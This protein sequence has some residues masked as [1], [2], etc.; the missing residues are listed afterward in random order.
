MNWS[1]HDYNVWLDNHQ[2]E[3]ARLNILRG[4]IENHVNFVRSTNKDSFV[5]SYPILVKL[6]KTAFE[7]F[8]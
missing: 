7:S 5:S 6:L 8:S 3:K 2:N 1:M 4:C